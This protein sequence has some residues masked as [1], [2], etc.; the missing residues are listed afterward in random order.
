MLVL[1][2]VLAHEGQFRAIPGAPGHPHNQGRV[3]RNDPLIHGLETAGQALGNMAQPQAHLEIR[4][5]RS[6]QAKIEQVPGW[7]L[8]LGTKRLVLRNVRFGEAVAQIRAE[9]ESDLPGQRQFRAVAVFSIQVLEGHGLGQED[10]I[11]RK[12][13]LD[14]PHSVPIRLEY[15]L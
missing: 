13:H 14:V 6:G 4:L 2:K 1:Q 12:A 8:I 5:Q 9:P 10:G 7:R 11:V 3:F 15:S